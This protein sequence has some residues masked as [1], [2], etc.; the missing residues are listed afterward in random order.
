[1][2]LALSTH[3]L[4]MFRRGINA[5]SKMDLD[6]L[7]AALSATRIQFDDIIDS[8]HPFENAEEAI[9]KVWQGKVVG[10]VVL[11]L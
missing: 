10:K 7:C 8:V 6:D 3:W 5:G 2:F 4:T 11:Q 1:L 9:E